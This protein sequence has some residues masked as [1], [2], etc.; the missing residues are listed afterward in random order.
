VRLADLAVGG[1]VEALRAELDRC[2]LP[3]GKSLRQ[4]YAALDHAE[5]AE[6]RL[7]KGEALV[8]DFWTRRNDPPAGGDWYFAMVIASNDLRA[9]LAAEPTV[10]APFEPA[11]TDLVVAVRGDGYAGQMEVVQDPYAEPA[12]RTG[13]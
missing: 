11:P 8:K 1:E 2:A 7:R 10:T 5:A 6:A 9:A 4:F 3:E 13:A 12:E